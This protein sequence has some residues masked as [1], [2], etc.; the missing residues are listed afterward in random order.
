MC[1]FR[2]A[3]FHRRYVPIKSV[4]RFKYLEGIV[5]SDCSINAELITQI[6]AV[7]SEYGRLRERFFDSYDLTLS[8]KLKVSIKYLTPLLT[9]GCETWTLIDKTSVNSA[10]SSN[11]I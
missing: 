10:Q 8:I 2:R 4:D 6:Q 11:V 1:W 7:S 5:T 9:Y 3:V